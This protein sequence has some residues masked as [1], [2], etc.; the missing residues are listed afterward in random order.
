MAEETPR[1]SSRGSSLVIEPG[2]GAARATIRFLEVLAH[3]V[4]VGSTTLSSLPGGRVCVE[5]CPRRPI[6]SQTLILGCCK[7]VSTSVSE[8]LFTPSGTVV[9]KRLVLYVSLS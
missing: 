1:S 2:D 3:C 6:S 4:R 8:S 9:F 7:P 5:G